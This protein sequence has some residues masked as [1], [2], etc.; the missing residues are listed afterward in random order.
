MQT[1]QVQLA[2][3]VHKVRCTDCIKLLLRNRVLMLIEHMV[4]IIVEHDREIRYSEFI[5]SFVFFKNL[6]VN[7]VN[8]IK[9]VALLCR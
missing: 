2:I 3:N 8:S 9:S 1:W 6:L 7:T 4:Y 5:T